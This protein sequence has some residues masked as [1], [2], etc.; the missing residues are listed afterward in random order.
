MQCLLYDLF[1]KVNFPFSLFNELCW[2]ISMCE[3]S[4][5]ISCRFYAIV[6]RKDG[7]NDFILPKFLRLFCGLTHDVS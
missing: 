5:R 1:E 6:V 3:G 7:W 2:L 4:C